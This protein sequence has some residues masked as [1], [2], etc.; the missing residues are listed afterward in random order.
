MLVG[1]G[2]SR[3]RDLFVHAK[4][5]AP[6]IVFIDE[7][8]AIGRRRGSG[9]LNGANDEREQTLNQI[10]TEMD[11]FTGNEGV[12]VLAA[13]NRPEILDGALLRGMSPNIGMVSALPR[14]GEESMLA[15]GAVTSQRT[16]QTIDDEVKRLT[17]ESYARALAML[18]EHRQQLDGLAEALLAHE[19]LDETQAH[20]AAGI[21]L[22][23][24]APRESSA[25]AG[26]RLG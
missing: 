19:T 7:L 1:V 11:G 17:D 26:A 10:L 2:A 20:R 12:I 13:T 6:A 3:V 16:L 8:D 24:A 14:P 25:L 15:G 21:E 9:G 5:E 18:S 22:P 4:E 23:P